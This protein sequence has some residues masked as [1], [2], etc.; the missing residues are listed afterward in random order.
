M[1]VLLLCLL[2]WPACALWAANRSLCWLDCEADLTLLMLDWRSKNANRWPQLAPAGDT[3]ATSAIWPAALSGTLPLTQDERGWH[4]RRLRPELRWNSEWGKAGL[5][6]D[7]NRLRLR[8][9]SADQ[10]QRWQLTVDPD[11]V[12]FEFRLFY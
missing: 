2:L 12:K 10:L 3:A 1:R 5:R 4:M 11:N 7:G 8:L 9:D 6:L